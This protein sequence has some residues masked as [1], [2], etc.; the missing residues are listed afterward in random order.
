MYC[1]V[2]R[3]QGNGGREEGEDLA[4]VV[5]SESAVIDGLDGLPSALI[6]LLSP[7]RGYS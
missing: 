1:S 3:P 6:C 2:S 5:S 4:V 7:T